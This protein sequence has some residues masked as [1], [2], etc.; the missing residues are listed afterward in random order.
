MSDRKET[1]NYTLYAMRVSLYSG[2][3]RS[4]LIVNLQPKGDSGG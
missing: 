2:K 4:Y 3:A 1:G